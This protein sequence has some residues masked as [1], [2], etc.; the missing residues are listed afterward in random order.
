MTHYGLYRNKHVKKNSALIESGVP[1]HFSEDFTFYIYGFA[2]FIAGSR[3]W[4]HVYF[5]SALCAG[6]S[7]PLKKTAAEDQTQTFIF[8]SVFL[9]C[10]AVS[11]GF[12]TVCTSQYPI[13]KVGAKTFISRGTSDNSYL[14]R[15]LRTWN[16]IWYS[17][18]ACF[19]SLCSEKLLQS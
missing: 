9:E 11:L 8:C 15:A 17:I 16:E 19:R 5:L 6:L 14:C 13:S 4:W 12:L 18:N 1:H 3:E 7:L 10:C 2:F